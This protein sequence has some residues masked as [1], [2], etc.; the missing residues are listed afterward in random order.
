MANIHFSRGSILT[1][2][3]IISKASPSPSLKALYRR[4]FW[5][6]GGAVLALSLKTGKKIKVENDDQFFLVPTS[7][8]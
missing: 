1:V 2:V 7:F 4:S 5:L 6:F 3:P 8:F